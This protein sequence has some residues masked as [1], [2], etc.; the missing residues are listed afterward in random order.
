[1]GALG[2]RRCWV[3]AGTLGLIA[4]V[5]SLLAGRG[6]WWIGAA[7]CAV[8]AIDLGVD[9][10][11]VRRLQSRDPGWQSRQPPQWKFFAGPSNG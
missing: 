8:W 1:M 3:I 2:L 7:L 4:V 10:P 6:N 11:L 5:V 9:A